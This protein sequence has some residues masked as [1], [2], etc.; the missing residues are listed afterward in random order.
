MSDLNEMQIN[1]NI[2]YNC[3]TSLSDSKKLDY[4]YT[5]LIEGDTQ[6]LLKKY[7]PT[8]VECTFLTDTAIFKVTKLKDARI[9]KNGMFFDGTIL[10][11]E[12]YEKIKNGYLVTYDY[13]GQENP[14]CLN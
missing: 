6:K 2:L 3:Y 11:N 5:Y 10:L 13:I 7:G 4:L 8:K 9:I 1:E 14:I 12:K